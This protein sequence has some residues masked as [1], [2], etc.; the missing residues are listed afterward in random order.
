MLSPKNGLY[1]T[2]LRLREHWEDRKE[3][4]HVVV[5]RVRR[6]HNNHNLTAAVDACTGPAQEWAHRQSGIGGRPAQEDRPAPLC[7]SEYA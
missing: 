4:Q 1:A 2:P 7:W 6:S 3:L 5:P